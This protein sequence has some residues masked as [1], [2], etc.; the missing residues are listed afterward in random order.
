MPKDIVLAGLSQ[1]YSLLQDSGVSIKGKVERWYATPNDSKKRKATVHFVDEKTS[2]IELD[3]WAI[4]VVSNL[5][6]SSL[7]TN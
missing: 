2:G 7:P 6:R 3:R 1:N 4:G 5:R